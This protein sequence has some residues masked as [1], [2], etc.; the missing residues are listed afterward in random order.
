MPLDRS[1][2]NSA[3]AALAAYLRGEIDNLTLDKE[4]FCGGKDRA[5]FKVSVQ[6]WRCYCDI[7]RHSVNASPEGWEFLTRCL[8][9]FHS[10]LEEPI[11]FRRD[12]RCAPF[13][14]PALWQAH[15]HLLEGDNLPAYDPAQHA[16]MNYLDEAK[17]RRDNIFAAILVIIVFVLLFV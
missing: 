12:P 2:R 16:R 9:Y 17:H 10:D 6:I 1:S 4:I 3:A 7:R 8:A 5:L 15:R 13:R 14:T 11:R